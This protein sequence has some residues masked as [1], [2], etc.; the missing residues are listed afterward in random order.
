MNP[1]VGVGLKGGRIKMTL[2]A[3]ST[4][5]PTRILT[6]KVI[7]SSKLE[8]GQLIMHF[9]APSLSFPF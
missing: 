6:I 8:D 2:P 4:A 5:M 7:K 9:L 1:D 3:T